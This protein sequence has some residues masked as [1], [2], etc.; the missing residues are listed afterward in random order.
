[1]KELNPKAIKLKDELLKLIDKEGAGSGEVVEKLKELRSFF[2]EAEDPT[3]TKVLRLA[4]EH[5]DENGTF[6]L[7][8]LSD[9]EVSEAEA[10]DAENSSEAGEEDHAALL[11]EYSPED[12]IKYLIGLC[13]E[14]DNKYNREELYEIRDNL[15][16]W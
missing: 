8:I 1:M 7:N 13:F 2:I 12:N 9:I 6:E 15:L 16:N 5:I 11:E 10:S 3:V 4:A 14:A